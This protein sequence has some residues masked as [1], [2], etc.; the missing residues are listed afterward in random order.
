[1]ALSAQQRAA[2]N[3]KAAQQLATD[4]LS[5]AASGNMPDSYWHT[6]RRIFR[7]C[8]ALGASVEEAQAI[9]EVEAEKLRHGLARDVDMRL[10]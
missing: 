3:R 7:A 5:M 4:V 6:D 8:Q 9:G 2:I 10:F 1:M